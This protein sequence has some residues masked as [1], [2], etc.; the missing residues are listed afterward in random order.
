MSSYYQGMQARVDEATD[1]QLVIFNAF[2]Q[3]ANYKALPGAFEIFDLCELE[4]FDGFLIQG[5]RVWAPEARQ[6]LAD[7]IYALGK[8]LVSINYGLCHAT[9]VGTDNYKAMYGLVTTVLTDQHRVRPA[10][11]NGFAG[12]GEAMARARGY[13]DACMACG[14]TDARFYQGSWQMSEGVRIALQMLETP[15]DLPDVIFCCND[16]LAVGVQQTLQEHGLRIPEDVMVAGFD[17]R[18]NSQRAVPRITTVDRDFFGIGYVAMDTLLK[19]MDGAHPEPFVGSNVQYMLSPSC[20]YDQS[21][22]YKDDIIE[23]LYSMDYALKR[24]YEVLTRFQPAVLGANTMSEL[25]RYCELYLPEMQ[26][27]KVCI[28]VNSEYRSYDM[29]NTATSYGEEA[30]LMAYYDQRT[31][32]SHDDEHVYTTFRTR[33]LLPRQLPMGAGTYVVFS[34]HD[35]QTCIGTFITEGVS[36][37]QKYGFIAFIVALL[38]SSIESVRKKILLQTINEHLDDLY[39]HDHLTGLF[40]RFGL[41]R[42]G[43]L[44]YD[45]ILRDFGQ[46]ELIFIDVDRMKLI[47]D[48]HGHEAGDQAL[49]DTAQIIEYASRGENAFSM[50]FGGDEFLI[51]CRRNLIPKMERALAQLNREV[52]RPYELSLSMGRVNV[53][54]PEHLSMEEAVNRADMRMYEMKRERRA[55]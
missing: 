29:S 33:D 22:H 5:N 47:N 2:G 6:Q 27:P 51:I 9:S 35:Q 37:I 25:M 34:L 32:M 50:R 12:S 17:N 21:A 46:V 36:P 53:K 24:F 18:E 8:P 38:A 14:I 16:D 7:A 40:N 19:L 30:A 26:C 13:R 31:H 4:H 10:F 54:A 42:F 43:T 1:V 23:S 39:V 11:I 3:T 49:K 15:H 28:S 45:H 48:V 20:G 41:E 52:Q 55:G 44:A